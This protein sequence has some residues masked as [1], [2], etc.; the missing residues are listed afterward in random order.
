MT[1]AAYVLSRY[2]ILLLFL[3]NI[4]IYPFSHNRCCII[5]LYVLW[6]HFSVFYKR[7]VGGFQCVNVSNTI[8]LIY[9]F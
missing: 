7:V 2:V 6:G 9:F 8:D 4:S 3:F 5:S 1:V